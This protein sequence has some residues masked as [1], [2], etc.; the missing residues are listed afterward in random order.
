M[1]R[2]QNQQVARANSD[3]DTTASSHGDKQEIPE[4]QDTQPDVINRLRKAKKTKEAKPKEKFLNKIL[5]KTQLCAFHMNGACRFGTA[6]NFA[7]SP[8]EIRQPPNFSKTMLCKEFYEGRCHDPNCKFA[9][10]QSEMRIA[11]RSTPCAWHAQGA[12]RNGSH[13]PYAHDAPAKP[14]GETAAVPEPLQDLELQMR[15]MQQAQLLQSAELM[16]E[17]GMMPYSLGLGLGQPFMADMDQAHVPLPWEP[18]KVEPMKVPLPWEMDMP[19]AEATDPS[20]KDVQDILALLGAK[21]SLEQEIMRTLAKSCAMP[22][23][24]MNYSG[25][26]QTP[27]SMQTGWGTA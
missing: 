19:E 20:V 2:K 1:P 9:H 22:N 16:Q 8:S 12:C 17:Q 18:M 14:I 10:S 7:H 23:D 13:C 11:R 5:N 26:P 15:M 24:A 21:C 27:H 6:C 4:I 3:S 25:Y